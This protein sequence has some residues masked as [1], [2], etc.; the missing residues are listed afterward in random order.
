[1]L[2]RYIRFPFCANP[3]CIW[4]RCREGSTVQLNQIIIEVVVA[5]FWSTTPCR[6]RIDSHRSTSVL[7]PDYH[8]LPPY[9]FVVTTDQNDGP[10]NAFFAIASLTTHRFASVVPRHAD[11]LRLG[12]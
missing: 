3:G 9:D 12:L 2:N 1:M 7:S 5:R 6:N 4:R 11:A 8:K 10:R